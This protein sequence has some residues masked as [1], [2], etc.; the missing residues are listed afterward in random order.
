MNIDMKN[1]Y[2]QSM[3][4]NKN[5]KLTMNRG[6]C[7]H[8]FRRSLLLGRGGASCCRDGLADC[9]HSLPVITIATVLKFFATQT[10]GVHEVLIPNR[11]AKITGWE[12]P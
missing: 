6:S 12:N 10:V 1:R 8:T 3:Y 7:L 5:P 11:N 2:K 4:M 9:R